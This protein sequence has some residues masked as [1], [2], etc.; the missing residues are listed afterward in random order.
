LLLCNHFT[1]TFA[2]LCL[3]TGVS[4]SYNPRRDRRAA[5]CRPCRHHTAFAYAR[6]RKLQ[7]PP[8]QRAGVDGDFGCPARSS[9]TNSRFCALIAAC[10]AAVAL[11]GCTPPITG[12]GYKMHGESGSKR[13]A[14]PRERLGSWK[15]IAAYLQRDVRIVQRWEPATA[16]PSIAINMIRSPAYTHSPKKSRTGSEAA[17]SRHR[18]AGR[19]CRMR[20]SPPPLSPWR[21][22]VRRRSLLSGCRS[23]RRCTMR[24]GRWPGRQSSRVSSAPVC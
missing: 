12:T 1:S 24:L 23:A 13:V 2:V 8:R 6:R 18:T 20:R 19:H 10:Q 9:L 21:K 11:G 5:L 7:S 22:V 17:E 4:T 15:E 14:L 16:C 3:N